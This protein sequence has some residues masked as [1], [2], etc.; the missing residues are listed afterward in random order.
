MAKGKIGSQDPLSRVFSFSLSLRP[1]SHRACDWW[2][3]PSFLEDISCF[4]RDSLLALMLTFWEGGRSGHRLKDKGRGALQRE[5]P[6]NPGGG[7]T[8][9]GRVGASCSAGSSLHPWAGLVR[10]STYPTPPAGAGTL[11]GPVDL[12]P[13]AR[14]W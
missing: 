2:P 7:G 11:P 14:V 3:C 12:R 9:L 8:W 6:K 5:P 13:E 10:N 4:S 1:G